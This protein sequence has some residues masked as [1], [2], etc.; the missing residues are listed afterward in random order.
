V[1][2]AQHRGPIADLHATHAAIRDW[3]RDHGRTIGAA[4]WE[5]YGDWTDPERLETSISYLLG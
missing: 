4:S 3:C 2:G 5:I 1:A